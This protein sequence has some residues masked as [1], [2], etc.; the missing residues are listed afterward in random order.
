MMKTE[1][2]LRLLIA[3]E[4]PRPPTMSEDEYRK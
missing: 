2:A 4:H 3:M 1:K